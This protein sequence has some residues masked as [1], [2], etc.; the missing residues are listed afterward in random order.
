MGGIFPASLA[1]FLDSFW[2]FIFLFQDFSHMH[3]V[4]QWRGLV[5]G[6]STSRLQQAVRKILKQENEFPKR[7][8]KRS[9]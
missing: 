4:E 2:K 1:S 5:A 6:S 3:A 8:Q 9:Q 7:I